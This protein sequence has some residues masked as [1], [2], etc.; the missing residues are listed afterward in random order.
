MSAVADDPLEARFAPPSG[1]TRI[2]V[3]P[4]SFG[5]YLRKLPL[6]N[7]LP[8]VMLYNGTPKLN[9]DAHVAVVDMDVGE[10]DLQQCA[11][12]VIRL[13]VEYQ[14]QHG[15]DVCFTLT[16][17]AP[18]PWSRFRRGE[19]P[20][21]TNRAT[22][23]AQT[24][25][26][27]DGAKTW[28]AYLD[29]L[30]SYAG[31]RSLAHDTTLLPDD[32][33]IEPGDVFDEPGSPGHAVLVVDVAVA[34]NDPSKRVFMLVQSYMPAQQIQ[35]LKGPW[36]TP[37]TPLRTPEWTFPSGSRRRLTKPACH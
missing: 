35:V 19:R 36:F 12:A 26:A 25:K 34:D 27:D 18:F 10:H 24:A 13:F 30:F 20:H 28:R 6:F 2:A 21:I 29:M 16:S 31:T 11:D 33:P 22:T 14:R 7:G 32:A 1:Y 9:Q 5:A 8:G 23:W 4:D 37:S 3:A 17:G 15:D